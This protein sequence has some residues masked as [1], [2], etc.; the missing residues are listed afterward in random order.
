MSKPK[1]HHVVPQMLLRNFAM[2]EDGG[3]IWQARVSDEDDPVSVAIKDAAV[4]KHFYTHFRDRPHKD[5]DWFW[6]T[7]LAEWE[8]KAATALRELD[9]DPERL[10]APAQALVLLQLLRTPLGQAQLAA[11]AAAERRRVFAADSP[12]EWAR[13]WAARK[14]R[15][16]GIP[17]WETLQ[18]VAAAARA[19]NEHALLAGDATAALDEM[20]TVLVHSGLGERLDEDGHWSILNADPDRFIIGDEPVTY[21]GQADP[22]RPIWAGRDPGQSDD[23]DLLRPG[24]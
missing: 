18:K 21:S 7:L 2:P 6:E 24:D 15:I 12:T 20:M 16:P 4:I 5:D 23:A 10:G 3:R 1:R 17:E 14:G 8:G 22:A 19:G 13:W 11:Q 9:A